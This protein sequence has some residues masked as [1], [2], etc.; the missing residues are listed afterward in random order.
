MI[1]DKPGAEQTQLRVAEIG[2]P[3][4]VPDYAAVNVMNLI[5]G[6]LFSSRINLNLREDH[7][8]TYGA[9]SQYIFRKHAGPF[10][11]GSGV[12]TNVTAPAVSEILKEL[13]RMTDTA[14]SADELTMGRDALVRSLPADWETNSAAVGS[15]GNLYIYDLGLDFYA[16]F[17]SAVSGVTADAVQ[18]VA[19]KYL[20]P[21]KIVVVAVG[22]RAKIEAELR[23]LNLGAVEI[24]N[25][26][27]T[28]KK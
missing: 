21:D 6:G 19:K 14:V 26:D 28:V 15:L 18:A 1:V 11:V 13:K 22:D 9:F 12:R 27:G 8:Y 17:P 24:R 23:K 3:R 16:T 7:G 5:L 4:S 20:H 25:P 2:A 10:W